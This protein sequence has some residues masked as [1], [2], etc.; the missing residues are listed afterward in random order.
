[1]RSSSN[2]TRRARGWS[3]V[4]KRFAAVAC[5]SLAIF[6]GAAGQAG[7][8]AAG[9]TDF[10][11]TITS[12]EPE[13]GVATLSII[14]GDSF[15]SLAVEP[16]HTAEVRG[17]SGEPYLRFASDGTVMEN[18]RS[19]TYHLNSSRYADAP[20]DHIDEGAEPEWFEVAADGEYAWHDHRIHWMGNEN[21]PD[22]GPG[23]V[24]LTSDIPI[25]V[26]DQAVTV[27]VRSVWQPAPSPWPAIVGA[28]V[29]VALVI[30]LRRTRGWL[31]SIPVGI[32]ALAATIIGAVEFAANPP[33]AQPSPMPWVLPGMSLVFVVAAPWLGRRSRRSPD[34]PAM[35][36]AHTGSPPV[37]PFSG[38]DAL[39]I[40][41]GA[42]LISWAWM[43][44]QALVR[45]VLV[46]PIPGWVVRGAI[47]FV[48]IVGLATLIAVGSAGYAKFR[49]AVD[50]EADRKA[51]C[52]ERSPSA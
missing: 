39:L 36:S 37:V 5:L 34:L 42:A 3:I 14:G 2:R 48:A 40:I 11:T 8:D 12:I 32:A 46:H 30:F 17:Y 21:P 45:A 29:G 4:V 35:A 47:P 25:T 22:K 27:S 49:S 28:V 31:A 51:D 52:S 18:R 15:L 41:A 50:P 10:L 7:A 1:M 23:D 33:A 38:A 24:I 16:G 6:V 43:G 13:T 19:K 20:H 44:H 26:D 9:P